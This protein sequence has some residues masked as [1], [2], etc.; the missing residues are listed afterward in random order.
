MPKLS[1]A[2][3]E[4]RTHDP[5]LGKCLCGRIEKVRSG[6]PTIASCSSI[7]RYSTSLTCPLQDDAAGAGIPAG[8]IESLRPQDRPY[9]AG[10]GRD[11]CAQVERLSHER[12]LG[13]FLACS[14]LRFSS[15]EQRRSHRGS[16][17]RQIPA[18][19][20]VIE[21]DPQ[22]CS[23]WTP[24]SESFAEATRFKFDVRLRTV[25]VVID[26]GARALMA[27]SPPSIAAERMGAGGVVSS[28]ST[29][30]P[31]ESGPQP[32]NPATARRIASVVD[33]FMCAQRMG[34]HSSGG[35]TT[36]MGRRCGLGGGAATRRISALGS[37][38]GST[39]LC[40]VFTKREWKDGH[41]S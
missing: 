9:R 14:S 36:L 27:G 22:I 16:S 19:H 13:D 41:W 17:R 11:D 10:S 2:G 39:T 4:A 24:L 38:D 8:V 37:W 6:S 18:T 23:A 28:V 5:Q 7:P 26:P 40:G 1:R 3:D 30:T 12:G 20:V 34:N 33:A 21:V 15:A 29:F 35:H 32:E 25:K 31:V